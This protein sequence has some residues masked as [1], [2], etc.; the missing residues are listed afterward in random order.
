MNKAN[1]TLIVPQ[2][3]HKDYP[4]KRD[5]TLLTVEDSFQ[6]FILN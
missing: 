4:K 1:V 5:I 3:F 2:R 6:K